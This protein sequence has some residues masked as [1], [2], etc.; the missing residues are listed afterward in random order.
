MSTDVAGHEINFTNHNT[1]TIA[2]GDTRVIS[3]IE[4][5]QTFNVTKIY[6]RMG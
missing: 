2:G 5:A 1:E 6:T 3:V 4:G